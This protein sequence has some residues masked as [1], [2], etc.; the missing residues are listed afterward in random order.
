MN[1]TIEAKKEFET[2]CNDLV[3]LSIRLASQRNTTL[4]RGRS[5]Y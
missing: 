5:V 3:V 2:F 4:K 1:R